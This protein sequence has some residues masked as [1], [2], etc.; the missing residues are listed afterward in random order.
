M[1]KLKVKSVEAERTEMS[2]DGDVR[3]KKKKS[4][5]GVKKVTSE[6]LD[7]PQTF[8]AARAL[9][10]HVKRKETSVDEYVSLVVAVRSV[11]KSKKT[12]PQRIPLTSPLYKSESAEVCFI[13]KDPQRT[14]K[15]YLIE[16]GSC[17]VTKVLGVSKLKARY[18]TFESKRQLCDSYDL[19]LAD[20]RVLPLLPKLL[21]KHFFRSKKIPSSV[22]MRRDLKTQLETAVSSTYIH[23]GT[24]NVFAVKVG[25]VNFKAKQL[26]DN[27]LSAVDRIVELCPGGFANVQSI[28]L[29]SAMSVALPLYNS[30][31]KGFRQKGGSEEGEA[32]QEE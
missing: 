8:N 5:T 30:L 23:L 29:K 24:G 15:D 2:G 21:G 6:V 32:D 27:I 25:L 12:K 11:R 4:K 1:K 17:G 9:L 3:K 22:D 19:F 28:H 20:D 26:T 14:V 7:R 13:V 18:K 10:K 31:P 16:N